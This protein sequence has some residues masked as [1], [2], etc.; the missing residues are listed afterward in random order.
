M[1][2]K[3]AEKSDYAITSFGLDDEDEELI[4]PP[5]PEVRRA[6]REEGAALGFGEAKA[7]RAAAS[8]P[9]GRPPASD[10]ACSERFALRVRPE[11]R[12]RFDD[13]AWQLRTTKG[14]LFEMLL[15]HFEQ[16]QRDKS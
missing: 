4:K 5:S 2:K 11:D 9:Q 15:D 6:A 13:L 16:S 7:K 10:V 12:Q 14:A 8:K 3:P 1:S